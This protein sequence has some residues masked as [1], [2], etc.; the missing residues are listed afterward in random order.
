MKPIKNILVPI[1]FSDAAQNALIYAIKFARIAN[2]KISVLH[3]YHIPVAVVGGEFPI[4]N[5][6]YVDEIES[7]VQAKFEEIKRNFLYA[8]LPDYEFISRLGMAEEVIENAANSGHF[9]LIIM[10]THGGNALQEAL[11]STTTGMVKKSK[12][13]IL[14]IPPAVQFKKLNKIVYATDYGKI[15]E[16]ASFEI[17]LMLADIFHAEIDVL[18]INPEGQKL[19]SKETASG[20][21]LDQYLK[22]VKHTYHVTFKEDLEKGIEE[23]INTRNV[24]LLV[25]IPRKRGL[26]ESMFHNSLTK[27]MVFHT[28]IP[29]LTFHK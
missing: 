7:E 14:A 15:G 25:M 16:A 18:H 6:P 4:Y 28:H 20:V 21:L 27:K 29:L 2:A 17:L 5:G 19:T 10:G 9:D 1:D 26:F 13:P 8:D 12:L 24:D 22:K 23:F 3:A 11:G